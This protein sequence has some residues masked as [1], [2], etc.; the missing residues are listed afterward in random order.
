MRDRIPCIGCG[1][2]CSQEMCRTGGLIY[3]HYT[4]PC[5]ALIRKGTRYCCSLYLSDP[6][7]YEHF[8]EIGAGCC[9]PSNPWR[10]EVPA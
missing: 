6:L 10:R 3:G 5:P 7:R 2:C 1:F 9:L 4:N 8:L